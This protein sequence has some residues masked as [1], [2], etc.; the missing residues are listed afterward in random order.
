ML[1]CMRT[2][3]LWTRTEYGCRNSYVQLGLEAE[4]IPH[5]YPERTQSRLHRHL[6]VIKTSCNLERDL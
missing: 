5:V 1:L 2:Y 4:I 3:M 6:T